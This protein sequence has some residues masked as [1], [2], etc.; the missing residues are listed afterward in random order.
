MIHNHTQ[1]YNKQKNKKIYI[2][3]FLT[4][5]FSFIEFTT[6][7]LYNSLALIADAGHMLSDSISLF[8]AGVAAF[9]ASYPP[10]KKYTY[11]KG[12]VEVFAALINLII[13]SIVIFNIIYESF[14]RFLNLETINGEGVLIVAIIGLIVNIFVFFILHS[15]EKNINTEAAMLHVV[16]D[17]L[18]SLAAIVSALVIIFFDIPI[19]DPILSIFIAL[20][21]S[22]FVIK[23]FI[24]VSRLILEAAPDGYDVELI[25]KD[26]IKQKNVI[27]IHDF[28]LWKASNNLVSLTAH[29]D[30][31]DINSWT[32]TMHS[33]NKMLEKK[34]KITHITI[35]PETDFVCSLERKNKNEFT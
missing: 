5:I 21:L 31:K 9:F 18:G 32:D 17:L 30:V 24:K 8:I 22:T 10:N 26:I 14:N 2:A 12:K 16:F 20:L 15:G 29:I 23:T 35:Q 3:C 7:F 19:I 34:Y 25:K 11:G 1:K 4:L 28:H 27:N 33:I 6:G 13:I